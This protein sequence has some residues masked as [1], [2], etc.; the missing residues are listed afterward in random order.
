METVSSVTAQ[1]V[2]SLLLVSEQQANSKST[3][4]HST[5]QTPRWAVLLW[6][7]G[8]NGLWLKWGKWV[9]SVTPLIAYTKFVVGCK[10]PSEYALCVCSCQRTV[11]R[12]EFLVL[13]W[14]LELFSFHL[15]LTHAGN[16]R[17]LK[18]PEVSLFAKPLSVPISTWTLDSRAVQTCFSFLLLCT[19][20]LVWFHTMKFNVIS[21]HAM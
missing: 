17:F 8:Y 7:I 12:L 3:L 10:Q 19:I 14:P 1:S 18:A 9:V 13:G 2:I 21:G 11:K 20:G 15:C 5:I 4:N 6:T 16:P